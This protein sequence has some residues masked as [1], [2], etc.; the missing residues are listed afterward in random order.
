MKKV[1]E[2]YEILGVVGNPQESR[3][4]LVADVQSKQKFALKALPM[5]FFNGEREFKS[6]QQEFEKVSQLKSPYVVRYYKLIGKFTEAFLLTE[7]VEGKNLRTYVDNQ[8]HSF[9]EL[10]HVAVQIM[11]GIQYLHH[12]KILHQN[13]KS[14]NILL[15]DDLNVKLSDFYFSKLFNR[16]RKQRG[17]SSVET[18]RYFSPEQVKE[19]SLDERSDFYSIGVVLFYL[20]TRVMPIRGTSATEIMHKHL[21]MNIVE[22]PSTINPQV[23]PEISIMVM[24]MLE[25]KPRKR[26]QSLSETILDL[27]R[28]EQ[29][30]QK[31]SSI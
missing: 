27:T 28:L 7:Y 26:I 18:I 5:D 2:N 24:K 21:R 23:P 16:W 14:T 17:Y 6:F 1:V 13:L 11:K 29:K 22:V 3:V 31:P 9:P 19:K 25:K 4:F 15:D 20:F 8:I 30:Q 10:L 12:F